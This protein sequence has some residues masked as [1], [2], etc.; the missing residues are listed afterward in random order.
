MIRDSIL[1]IVF[2]KSIH[3][4]FAIYSIIIHTIKYMYNKCVTT[5]AFNNIMKLETIEVSVLWVLKIGSGKY[6]NT[7]GKVWTFSFFTFNCFV[8]WYRSDSFFS[9]FFF[10]FT[11]VSFNF[12]FNSYTYGFSV[13][14]ALL[15]GLNRTF[16]MC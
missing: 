1:H 14:C 13:R 15:A 16:M 11:V 10:Y 4:Y 3:P 6:K 5:T 12:V 8:A 2:M 7:M 9:V